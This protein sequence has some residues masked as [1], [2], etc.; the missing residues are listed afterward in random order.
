MEFRILGS[1][2]IGDEVGTVS[3][4]GTR[5]RALL[6]LFLAQPNHVIS[7]DRLI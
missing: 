6:A 5:L 7:T 1:L 3:F 2:E 4:G